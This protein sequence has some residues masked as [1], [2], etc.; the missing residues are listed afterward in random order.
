MYSESD[1]LDIQSDAK[2]NAAGSA[3][4]DLC[5]E[6]HTVFYYEHIVVAP[7]CVVT[8]VFQWANSF[9][10]HDILTAS[11]TTP[12]SNLVLASSMSSL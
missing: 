3:G 11:S 7:T 10:L 4:Y 1:G 2:L 5:Y 12:D 6:V 9:M 8:C